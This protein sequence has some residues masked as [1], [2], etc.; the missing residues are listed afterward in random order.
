LERVING[1]SPD[2]YHTFG[3]PTKN[4]IASMDKDQVYSLGN[5]K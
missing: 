5:V 2:K 3:K 4:I 1:K